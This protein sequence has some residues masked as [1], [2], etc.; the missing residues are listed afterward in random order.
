MTGKSATQG[1]GKVVEISGKDQ[2]SLRAT[3]TSLME[4]E[5]LSQTA[6]ARECGVS[7]SLFSNWLAGKYE[8][9]NEAIAGTMVKWLKARENRSQIDAALLKSP[10]YIETPTGEKIQ[11]VLHYG[12]MAADIVVCY[13][14]AGLGKT[15]ALKRY[16]EDHLN[17]WMVTMSPATASTGAAL[18]MIAE[19]AGI[20]EIPGRTARIQRVIVDR[21]RH[22]GGLLIVDEAQHLKLNALEAIRSLY[23]FGEIGLALCGN[24]LVYAGLTGGTRTATF[25]Q[26]FSRIGKRLHLTRATDEDV[27][28][29]AE[30]FAITG[31]SE[32]EALLKIAQKP[33]G[34]RGVVKT[35]SMAKV[36]A[37]GDIED[38]GI[39]LRHIDMAWRNLS[40]A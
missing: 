8:G 11:S 24:E 13:G 14:G 16:V 36:L 4:K 27:K 33:G 32:M 17:C 18:E 25:A 15:T 12:Q 31:K 1:D 40:V 19:A 30:A 7:S 2:N 38:D 39:C 9:D 35:I 37:F 5:G 26:L 29:L 3:V 22:T 6:V 34:L 23:D 10:A 21:F 20:K 28:A